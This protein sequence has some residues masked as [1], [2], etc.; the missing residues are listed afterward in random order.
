MTKTSKQGK[1]QAAI[2][3]SDFLQ[4]T[5]P[6]LEKRVKD[7]AEEMYFQGFTKYKLLAPV[8]GLHCETS[9]CSGI[10]FFEL[11]DMTPE[12]V[13]REEPSLH[14]LVFR[15]RNCELRRKIYA[16]R[17]HLGPRGV[18]GKLF[19]FGEDPAFGPPTPSNVIS[20]VREEKDYY[21]KGRRSENQGLGI[22][23]FA[24]YRRVIENQK[25]RIFNEIIRVSEKIGASSEILNELK[26]A[27]K[28]T[29]FSKAVGVVRHGIPQTLL[30]NGH[31]PLT[32]LH[33]ALSEGLHAQTD[34]QCLEL[35]RSI[36]VVLTDLVDKMANALKDEAD[37]NVAVG[38]LINTQTPKP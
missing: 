10:R 21:L 22:A 23:A 26:A 3:V 35:A 20:L 16:L 14:F 4:N 31:N 5:P 24:Y 9:C 1:A 30:I 15:C 33:S 12:I 13:R 34:E 11:T 38:R 37:L 7:M 32:L 19:K 6:G 17:S 29:Q 18:H 27:K 2:S 8:V 25:N 28:E 36:R